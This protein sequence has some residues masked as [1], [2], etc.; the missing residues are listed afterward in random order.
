MSRGLGDT[1]RAALTLIADAGDQAL[2][3][4]RL[5][6]M[7]GTD[8]Q[9]TN[10]LID[11]LADRGHVRVVRCGRYDL[12]KAATLGAGDSVMWRPEGVWGLKESRWVARRRERPLT[13]VA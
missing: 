4:S 11:S 10:R 13:L 3:M 9:Q 6:E 8:R 2:P 5:G 1:Q 7:L 12:Q